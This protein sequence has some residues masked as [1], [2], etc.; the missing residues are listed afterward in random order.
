[1][2]GGYHSLIYS[3]TSGSRFGEVILSYDSYV[4]ISHVVSILGFSLDVAD[5]ETLAMA[6]E[7]PSTASSCRRCSNIEAIHP[8]TMALPIV[9]CTYEH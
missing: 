6:I 4:D 1:M 5:R 9:P 7:S 8:L 2:A 3:I